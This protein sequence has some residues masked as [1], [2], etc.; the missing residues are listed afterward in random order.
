MR[1]RS[2]TTAGSPG[3]EK[4]R[5]IV[6]QKTVGQYSR[7][8][9]SSYYPQSKHR[10][11]DIVPSILVKQAHGSG[12]YQGKTSALSYFSAP[13]VA[14]LSSH[15]SLTGLDVHPLLFPPACLSDRKS[16]C[17]LS[18]IPSSQFNL[19]YVKPSVV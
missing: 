7:A 15:V 9:T 16:R 2:A 12:A 4:A 10:F 1:Q 13:C 3:I 17:V 6:R 18:V 11:P 8:Y 14:P 19:V 5:S